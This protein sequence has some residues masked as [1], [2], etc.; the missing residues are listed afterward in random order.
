MAEKRTVLIGDNEWLVSVMASAAELTA[1]LS[2]VASILAGNGMLFDMGSDQ[3]SI[4]INMADM[5]FSLDI[6]FINSEHG[7]VGILR[8]VEPGEAVAFDAGAGNGARYFLEVNAEEAEGV[9]VGDIHRYL[10]SHTGVVDVQG[11]GSRRVV[12][13][14]GIVCRCLVENEIVSELNV[15]RGEEI[16]HVVTSNRNN[17]I[18]T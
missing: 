14:K 4:S 10:C 6:V 15:A 11:T 12:P 3:G 5:L 1:G 7:V 16:K 17:Q 9:S 13:R 18:P 2:G 8:E